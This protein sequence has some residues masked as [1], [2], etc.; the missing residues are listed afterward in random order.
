MKTVV[1]GC[2]CITSPS[3]MREFPL[4]SIVVPT[5]NRQMLLVQLLQTIGV[6]WKNAGMEYGALEVVV[7]D[8]AST[9]NTWATL[10][11]IQT[12][13]GFLLRLNRNV[14]NI[15]FT[16]NVMAGFN[17]AQGDWIMVCGDDDEMHELGLIKIFKSLKTPRADLYC[18]WTESNPSHQWVSREKHVTFDELAGKYYYFPGNCGLAV[19]SGPLVR[20]A[21]HLLRG[22]DVRLSTWA[23]MDVYGCAAALS[24]LPQ[25]ICLSPE[26]I[27]RHPNL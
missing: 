17:M 11:K 24:K 27:A 2:Q 9:D 13:A 1:H 12:E 22:K 16:G 3:G 6:A 25:P 26:V 5:Y 19:A 8:N 20:Q 10:E 7:S 18:F 14:V 4:L 15:G 21:A 23:I